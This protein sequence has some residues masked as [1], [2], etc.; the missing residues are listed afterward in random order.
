MIAS[1]LTTSP[2]TSPPFA[3]NTCLAARTVPTTVP[4]I[5]TTPSASMSPTT[6]IPPP[7]MESPAT[8]SPPP[9]PAPFSVNSAISV[10]LLHQRQGIERLAVAPDF[11]MQMRGGRPPRAAGQSD[12]L[13]RLDLVTLCHEQPGGV[14]IHRLIP[15]QMPQEH[16]QP[17]IGIVPRGGHRA[18]ARRAHRG[19]D[20]CGD[21]DS[22]MGLAGGAGPYLTARHEPHRLE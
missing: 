12:H 3:T 10:P 5:F 15:R 17:V 16:E 13:P 4:S 11:E 6:R 8:D 18:A 19:L 22:G 9:I 21:V 14:P 2:S 7:M 20:G 1:R